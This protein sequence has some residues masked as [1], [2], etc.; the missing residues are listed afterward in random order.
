MKKWLLMIAIVMGGFTIGVSIQE[1]RIIV[2][3][4]RLNKLKKEIK[5]RKEEIDELKEN[6]ESEMLKNKELLEVATKIS[7]AKNE[8][9]LNKILNSINMPKPWKGDFKEFMSNRNNAFDFS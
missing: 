6:I 9:D 5:Q 1:G 8:E 3:R 7:E 2:K 4:H